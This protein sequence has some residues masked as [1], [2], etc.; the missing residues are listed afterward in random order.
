MQSKFEDRALDRFFEILEFA[1]TD[2]AQMVDDDSYASGDDDAGND[3]GGE[4]GVMPPL[5]A[6]MNTPH[7]ETASHD[8]SP[9]RQLY[10]TPATSVRDEC[11]EKGSGSGLEELGGRKSLPRPG[12][13]PAKK[14]FVEEPPAEPTSLAE[15]P[16]GEELQETSYDRVSREKYK[17]LLRPG[18]RN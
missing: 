5:L 4:E 12:D 15:T 10:P 8:P 11:A 18:V 14:L 1:W 6:I 7:Q 16:K 3:D 2:E 9:D 17:Q 13:L